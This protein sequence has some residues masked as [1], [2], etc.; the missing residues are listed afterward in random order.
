MKQTKNSE[1]NIDKMELDRVAVHYIGWEIKW[2]E[3]MIG[4]SQ[5]KK[6][7][8]QRNTRTFGPY[9][10]SGTTARRS[11][12]RYQFVDFCGSNDNYR[13]QTQLEQ[14]NSMG[15]TNDVNRKKQALNTANGD[16]TQ[17]VEI[18]KAQSH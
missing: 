2:D 17:A 4:E 5:C 15:L 7:I 3:W 14:I 12:P 8:L 9:R 11:V 10:E 6:R 18:L 13:F 16:V 1:D